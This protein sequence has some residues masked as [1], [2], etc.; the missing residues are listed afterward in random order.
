MKIVLTL[1][2]R[3]SNVVREKSPTQPL[4]AVIV[5]I[6]DFPWH[7]NNFTYHSKQLVTFNSVCMNIMKECKYMVWPISGHANLF[8]T[9]SISFIASDLIFKGLKEDFPRITV[10]SARGKGR[11]P[12]KIRSRRCLG[13]PANAC[14]D[15]TNIGGIEIS[16]FKDRH[17]LRIRNQHAYTF[18]RY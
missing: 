16:S 5:P 13:G 18:E 8:K 7:V 9:I 3:I 2:A 15:S 14:A 6:I 10:H 17:D 1:N 4:F 12:L 11:K